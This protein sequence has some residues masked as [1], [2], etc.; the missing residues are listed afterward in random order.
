MSAR[1]QRFLWAVSLAVLLTGAVAW[2]SDDG[3]GNASAGSSSTTADTG[4]EPD[5]PDEPL[6]I[7]ALQPQTGAFAPIGASIQ[8]GVEF[9]VELWNSDSTHRQVEVET[10]D[11]QSTPEGALACYRQLASSVDVIIGPHLFPGYRAIKDLVAADGPPLLT[12]IP[13]SEAEAGSY[14][15]QTAPNIEEIIEANLAHV[16]SLGGTTVSTIT[17]NDQPGNLAKDAVAELAADHGIEVLVQESFDPTAQN[18]APQA[19]NIAG[20]EPDAVLSWTVGAPLITVLRSLGAAG[21]DVPILMGSASLSVPLLTQAGADA[22]EELL[23]AASSAFD[24]ATIDDADYQARVEEFNKQFTAKFDQAPDFNGYLAADA[25]FLAAQGGATA[26]SPD[27][28]RDA[29]ESGDTFESVLWGG[30]S[31]SADDHIGTADEPFTIL[32]WN[33]GDA[34][35]TVVE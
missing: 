12:A 14:I 17:S 20:S 35:W 28:V 26:T 33:L 7:G 9:G 2:G 19:E 13:F 21:V 4:A 30:Y 27:D 25:L 10:C 15:F 34:N 8:R 5:V 1:P 22:P 29:L 16:E 3:G 6:R 18:L 32:R 31:W 23:F 11:D 24:P